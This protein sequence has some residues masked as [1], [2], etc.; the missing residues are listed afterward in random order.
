MKNNPPPSNN[1][2][3]DLLFGQNISIPALSKTLEISPEDDDDFEDRDADEDWMPSSSTF[4][5]KLLQQC[6]L[7]DLTRD[8]GLSKESAQI[9]GSC[10]HESNLLAPSTTFAW[11]RNREAEFRQYF[12]K[13]GSLVFCNNVRGLIENMGT[14]T[15]YKPEEWRLFIDASKRSL[16]AVLSSNGHKLASIPVGHSI[17]MPETYENMRLLFAAINTKNMTG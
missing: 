15:C 8:L 1:P 4:E 14:C 6:Q 11:Y 2:S 9:L 5:P 3:P 7:N 16:K 13:E 12:S 10:L 17:K